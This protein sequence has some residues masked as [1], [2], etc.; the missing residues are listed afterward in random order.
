MLKHYLHEF[1]RY[2][3]YLIFR[4]RQKDGLLQNADSNAQKMKK[5]NQ[6]LQTQMISQK[7]NYDTLNNK[8]ESLKDKN[9][10]LEDRL[11]YTLFH[12]WFTNTNL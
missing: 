10:E 3:F 8:L 5:D 12:K 1:S 7:Q 4:C 9:I 11:R 6:Q 2:I